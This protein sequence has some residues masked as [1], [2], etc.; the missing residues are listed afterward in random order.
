M[1]KQRSVPEEM[2]PA[3]VEEGEVVTHQ[4]NLPVAWLAGTRKTA[5]VWLDAARDLW[6]VRARDAV[7]SKK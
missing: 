2:V 4:E 3:G 1:S 5:L 7:P 6:T